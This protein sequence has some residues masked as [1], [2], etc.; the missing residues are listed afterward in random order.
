VTCY[1][2]IHGASSDSWYW[3]R[4]IPRLRARGHDVVAPDLPID[5]DSAGLTEYADTVVDAIGNRRDLVVVAQSMGGFTGP[6]VCARVPADLLVLVAGMIPVPG[7]SPGDW[8]GNTGYTEARLAHDER[9][10][11]PS[12]ADQM[13]TFFHDVA[14]DV[15]AEARARGEKAQSGTPFLKS[16]PLDKW[17]EVPTE[18]LLCRQ[19]R[20]FPAEFMRPV[21]R[22]RLGITPDEMDS[23]HLPA[24]AHPD[25]LVE[26][27]ERYRVRHAL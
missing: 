7:E 5:D 16:W 8:W 9:E 25:E 22:Q 27:L 18:F 15:R 23:G 19:D 17:P 10:G 1:V 24:L 6:L 11:Y 3:H 12:D 4:V 14:A 2:L 26:R 13:D 21:V 20:F